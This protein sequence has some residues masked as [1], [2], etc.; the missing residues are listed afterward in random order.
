MATMPDTRLLGEHTLGAHEEFRGEDRLEEYVAGLSAARCA[1]ILSASP[2]PLPYL[3]RNH[4]ECR[5][6]AC[7]TRGFEEV[8]RTWTLSVLSDAKGG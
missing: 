3:V 4:R 2:L 1:E 6:E 8:L 5:V 7:E